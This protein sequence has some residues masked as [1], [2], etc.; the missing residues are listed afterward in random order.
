VRYCRALIVLDAGRP[1]GIVTR[2]DLFDRGLVRRRRAGQLRVAEIMSSDL[3]TAP[4]DL[5]VEAA[6][7]LMNGHRI[8]HLPILDRDEVIGILDR[9]ELISWLAADREARIGDLMFYITHG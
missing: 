3:V 4:V 8:S 2:R 9:V 5:D 7:D 6:L 1:I